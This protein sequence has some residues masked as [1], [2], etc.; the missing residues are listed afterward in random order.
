MAQEY[1]IALQMMKGKDIYEG[2]R[3]LIIEKDGQP[4][5]HPSSLDLVTNEFVDSHF[6]SLEEMELS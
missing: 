1:R 2:I 5:W 4:N 6:Q 3:A